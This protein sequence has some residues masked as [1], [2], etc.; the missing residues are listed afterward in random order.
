MPDVASSNNLGGIT[1][2]ALAEQTLENFLL[3]FP[4]VNSFTRDFT[5]D[6]ATRG[7]TVTTRIAS[8]LSAAKDFDQGSGNRGYL[9]DAVESTERVITLNKHK[10]K[11]IEFDDGQ[12]SK[13]GWPILQRLFVQPVSHSIVK[14]MMDDVMGLVTATNF[15]AAQ[16]DIADEASLTIDHLI[17]LQKSLDLVNC[18]MERFFIHNP[19][20]FA[21]LLKND[22]LQKQLNYG[23]AEP[24]RERRIPELLG[25]GLQTYNSIPA[26][27]ASSKNLV[28]FAGHKDA[29][30][31]A[32]RVPAEPQNFYGEVV[33]VQDRTSGLS[34]QLRSY[35]MPL[36]FYR[37]TATLLYGVAVGN[38]KLLKRVVVDV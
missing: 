31:I 5:A 2:H 28:G 24:I 18:P 32:A 7:E 25:L 12:L 4:L 29:I 10:Q 35:Y 26:N 13:G 33:T 30:I 27:T 3:E 17:D 1:L 38:E 23:G 14:A 37:I 15:G 16:V 11:T 36:G 21:A 9:P 8:D 6:I 20:I 34:I 19:S 22:A